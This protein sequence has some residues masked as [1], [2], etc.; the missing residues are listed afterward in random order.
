MIAPIFASF[1]QK[2]PD[3]VFVKVDSDKCNAL[4]SR[5]GVRALPT[6]VFMLR[7]A[8]VDSVRGADAAAL[9][10][11]IL[12]HKPIVGTTL[13]WGGPEPP[14]ASAGTSTGG[15][16]TSPGGA[17]MQRYEE[18][19][20]DLKAK[21]DAIM[22]IAGC[23]PR[24]AA[25]AVQKHGGDSD[26]A[27]MDALTNAAALEAL[28]ASQMPAAASSSSSASA[29]SAVSH[30]AIAALGHEAGAA[31]AGAATPKKGGG[32]ALQFRMASKA[33]IKIK[34]EFDASATVGAVAEWLR[35]KL[36]AGATFTLKTRKGSSEA[37]L[38]P[39]ATLAAAGLAPRGLVLVA[40][41][42]AV[43]FI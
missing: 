3:V 37:A 2:Y 9:E 8:K 34:E 28:A 6:F 20:A 43:A 26:A 14:A 32:A 25:A 36:P 24:I 39:S 1:A 15:A 23:T 17:T 42:A 33:T 22:A 10:K 21:A 11:A 12:E 30:A 16:A 29:S 19:S 4:A 38:D 31:G 18:L 35:T 7:G 13:S 40:D 41:C 5:N 27:A